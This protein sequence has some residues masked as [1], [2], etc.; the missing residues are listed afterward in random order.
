MPP[1]NLIGWSGPTG[2]DER[3]PQE[4][5]PFAFAVSTSFFATNGPWLYLRPVAARCRTVSTLVAGAIRPVLRTRTDHPPDRV[6]QLAQT[7]HPDLQRSAR[8][9]DPCHGLQRPLRLFLHLAI[10]NTC[11]RF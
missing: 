9:E 4:P 7:G 2:L 5:S 1:K 11:R 3:S 10:Q 8:V 6:V